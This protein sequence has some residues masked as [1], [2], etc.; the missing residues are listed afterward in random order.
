MRS[1]FPLISAMA[2]GL[3]MA[4]A[5][6]A[7]S[8]N[9]AEKARFEAD[10]TLSIDAVQDLHLLPSDETTRSRHARR[11]RFSIAP[12]QLKILLENQR[13]QRPRLRNPFD[14]ALRRLSGSFAFH[15]PPQNEPPA[16]ANLWGVASWLPPYRRTYTSCFEI[17]GG[18][19]FRYALVEPLRQG[20]TTQQVSLTVFGEAPM[21]P[22]DCRDSSATFF[23]PLMA[24][25]QGDTE[26]L[27]YPFA[28]REFR[29][30]VSADLPVQD[31]RFHGTFYVDSSRFFSFK[32]NQAEFDLL[33]RRKSMRAVVQGDP[34]FSIPDPH[35]LSLDWWQADALANAH[36][37]YAVCHRHAPMM[38]AATRYAGRVYWYTSGLAEP[39]SDVHACG[40]G[41]GSS[42][43]RLH[44]DG[45]TSVRPMSDPIFTRTN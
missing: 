35:P 37:W 20:A 38:I 25:L 39:T 21:H 29:H 27:P 22:T 33:L 19:G 23:M 31:L 9:Q 43:G 36:P 11:Y 30:F 41:S 42:S 2:V 7:R 45:E 16:I 18:F 14:K 1:A 34:L 40:S 13:M 28:S 32:L 15:P 5:V 17:S 44:S 10:T 26:V 4:D 3:A 8:P 12:E 24:M 6:M